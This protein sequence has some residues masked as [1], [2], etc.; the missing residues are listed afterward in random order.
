MDTNSAEQK[1]MPEIIDVEVSWKYQKLKKK[2]SNTEYLLL[3]MIGL[4][5]IIV[6]HTQFS[7]VF[8]F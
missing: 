1:K 8:K 5:K 7:Q 4:N 2:H 3:Y 6:E